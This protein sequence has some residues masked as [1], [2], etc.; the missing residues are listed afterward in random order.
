MYS[1]CLLKKPA[2]L[3]FMVKTKIIWHYI[4]EDLN[5]EKNEVTF[6]SNFPV[7]GAVNVCNISV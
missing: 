5:L 3:N 2:A 7:L 4:Q 6:Y 1:V